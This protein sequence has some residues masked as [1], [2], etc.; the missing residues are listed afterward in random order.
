MIVKNEEKYLGQCLNSV[1]EIV[2]E[3]IITDTGSTDKTKEIAKKFKAK[4]FDF[5]WNDDFSEAR[6]ES[7]K[8][9][10]KE[11]I[12]VL[13]ADE[14][15]DKNGLEKIKEAIEHNGN[16]SGFQLEQRSYLENYFEGAYENKS[17]LEQTRKY[18]FYISNFLA[19]L[20]R[21]NLGI[22]FK[23][24]VHELAEDSMNEQK[25]EFKKADI[26]IHHFGTL[27]ERGLISSKVDMYSKM[28]L[29]Q[30]EEHPD[31]P[32][33]LYQAARMY[34]SRNDL[35][36]ALKFFEMAAEIDPH[37]KLVF[38]EIA[39]IYMRMNDENK[40]IENFRKS[41]ELN[42]DNHSPANNLAVVYMS[43]GKFES[44]KKI[45]EEQLKKNPDNKALKYNYEE[46]LKNLK[47]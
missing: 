10:T 23:H 3:V 16:M 40:V 6:N 2:N 11:W 26:I 36:N 19:R 38:S 43:T 34:L 7:L 46:C 12:L 8:H 25:L 17:S 37:Y 13:D 24:R 9:A 30:Y 42:P 44:A 31:N 28:I 47:K 29:H 15:I 41:M 20:F 18:P 32:R 27:K 39:K 14:F 33:Y 5:K 22:H 45:L 35:P 1:K 4:I 21:N